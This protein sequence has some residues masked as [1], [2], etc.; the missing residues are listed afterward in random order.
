MATI[1]AT[2]LIDGF[3]EITETTLDGATDTFTFSGLKA[4]ILI[5]R[6]DTGGSI[7]PVITG[8]E[9]TVI[10]CEGVGDVDVSGGVSQVIAPGEVFAVRLGTISGFLTGVIA[11]ASGSG[12]IA[13]LIEK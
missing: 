5:M 12:L 3:K 2:S 4:P 13:Q 6:N 1:V 11:I 7:T 9:A 8:D 10:D